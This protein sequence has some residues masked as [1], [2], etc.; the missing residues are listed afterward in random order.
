MDFSHWEQS[1]RSSWRMAVLVGANTRTY[2]FALGAALLDAAAEGRSEILLRDLAVPYAMGLVRHLGQAPQVSQK[3]ERG[4]KDFLSVAE[5]EAA[6]SLRLGSPT[7]EL[8]AAAIDSMPRMVMRKFHNLR[9]EGAEVPHRFYE[10]TGRSHERVVRLSRELRDIALSEQA[11]SLRGELSA[12][13]SIVETSFAIGIGQSLIREGVVV[14][15]TTLQIT[16]RQRRRSVA[17]VTD[18][19]IGFQRGLCLICTDPIT[20]GIDSIAVDHVFPLSFRRLLPSGG[21]GTAPDL[22]AIWNLAP[23]HAG[24]NGQKSNRLPTEQEMFRLAERNEAIMQSPRPLRKTL[25]LTLKHSGYKST[26]PGEWHTFIRHVRDL[27]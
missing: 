16:D 21:K 12:R 10:V 4:E 1:P 13:W 19:V 9:G 22:D 15:M 8:L 23:T 2:K 26:R 11:T 6:E 5:R 14:D 7:E 25:E 27:L 3:G 17:G 24:C 20:L 18:A